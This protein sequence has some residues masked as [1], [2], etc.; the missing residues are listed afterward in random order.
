MSTAPTRAMISSTARDLPAHRQA[1]RDACMGLGVHPVMMEDLPA[2][3]ADAI[4]ASLEMVEEADLYIGIFANRYGYVPQ[5]DK[6]NPDRLGITEMEYRRA[7]ELGKP[8]LLFVATE[9]HTRPLEREDD[10]AA[11]ASEA[12]EKLERFLERVK[13]ERVVKFFGSPDELRAHITQALAHWLGY[14]FAYQPAPPPDPATLPERGKLP[15]GSRLDMP[16]NPNFVGRQDDLR[17]LAEQLLHRNGKATDTVIT[18]TAAATGVGGIGKTQ[19]AVEF[20]YRYGRYFYGVHWLNFADVQADEDTRIAARLREEIAACGQ[21]MHLPAFPE[22]LPEQ[23][24]ATLAAWR[25]SPP[26][27]LILDNVES[28]GVY[29]KVRAALEG[30]HTLVTSRAVDAQA[31]HNVGLAAHHLRTL[32]R[33]QSLE[34][35]RK[36]APHLRDVPDEELGKLAERL[37]DL[38][39]ALDIAGRYLHVQRRAELSVAE[40]LSKLE[41]NPLEHRSLQGW[42]KRAE[43]PTDHDLDV[44]ATFA[45]SWEQVSDPLA[46]HIFRACGYLAPNQPIPPELLLRLAGAKKDDPFEVLRQLLGGDLGETLGDM[47]RQLQEQDDDPAEALGD[48]LQQLLDYGLLTPAAEDETRLQIHPLLADFA[49]GQDAE[50]AESRLPPLADALVGLAYEA[51]D[52]GFPARFA[53]LRSHVERV[54]E[55]A[56][57]A[58]L[59]DA[60]TLW[61]NLG[62]HLQD[63]GELAAAKEHLERALRIWERALPPDHPAIATS[64]NNLGLVLKAMGEL[65]GAKEHH[66][67]VLQILEKSL[68]PDHPYVAATLNN[69]GSVL[70]DMGELAGAKEHHERALRIR[71]RALPPDHP[72]IAQSLNNLAYVLQDMGQAEQACALWR[73]ALRILEAKLPAGHPHIGVVRRALAEHCGEEGMG[74]GDNAADMLGLLVEMLRVIYAAAGEEGVRQFLQAQGVPEEVIAQIIARLRGSGEG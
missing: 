51:L 7:V 50:A 56:E 59:D 9:T 18:T 22:T 42:A 23:A 53:P 11:E 8:R 36:L 28:P 4:R 71:E 58:G 67:R 34:L 21:A 52:T 60:A 31:W 27:L 26:R 73:R 33:A 25:K 37:G 64:L 16:P 49:R 40:Y 43:S 63:M 65:A 24:A 66:E 69:L 72:D 62:A 46:Q 39:L 15:P 2:L 74:E 17:A 70:Q 12:A 57:K 1:A 29:Q 6:L 13:T 55:W 35:L 61:N 3:D 48:A 47:L 45:L 10:E 68:P 54:A 14:R 5:D 41:G 19:L 32:S 38:P 44:A 20:A 30:L